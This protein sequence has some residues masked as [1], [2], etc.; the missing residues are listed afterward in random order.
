MPAPCLA[1][2]LV[3]TATAATAL[4]VAVQAAGPVR[5]QWIAR[6]MTVDGRL[7]EWGDLTVVEDGL[8]VAAAN[9]ADSLVLAVST[10]HGATRLGLARGLV[11]WF[12]PA[13]KQTTDS[14]VQFPATV[15]TQ[16]GSSGR[17]LDPAH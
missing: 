9:D 1:R 3:I 15:D 4:A 7:D 2:I 13:G 5:S 17:P 6:D 16:A 14:G 8:A 11:L 10:N 12:A